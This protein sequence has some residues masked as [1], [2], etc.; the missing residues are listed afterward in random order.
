MVKENLVEY[1]KKKLAEKYS[2]D[3]IKLALRRL[4][5]SVEEINEAFKVV[6]AQLRPKPIPPPKHAAPPP[7]KITLPPRRKHVEE[8]HYEARETVSASFVKSVGEH[9]EMLAIAG[10]ILIVA[11]VALFAISM[12]RGGEAI[13]STPDGAEEGACTGFEDFVYQSH[14][15]E[16]DGDFEITLKSISS[17]NITITDLAIDN[18]KFS[19]FASTLVQP[20]QVVTLKGGSSVV[21]VKG[22]KYVKN[23]KVGYTT[24]SGK[25]YE[26]AACM[27]R[28]Q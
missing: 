10:T 2:H 26:E 6:E 7:K 18:L 15:L 9:R 8:E 23:V 21:G 27:G 1:I 4:G 17:K 22:S 14:S 20:D 16:D 11:F 12:L 25:G 19:A 24:D 5:Y 13:K 3:G 28:Y